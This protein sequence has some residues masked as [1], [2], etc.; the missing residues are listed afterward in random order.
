[1]TLQSIVWKKRI[2]NKFISLIPTNLNDGIA[3]GTIMNGWATGA[4]DFVD[5]MAKTKDD[6]AL[7]GLQVVVTN[8]FKGENV[9]A[10][11]VEDLFGS[12][13]TY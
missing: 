13:K 6:T 7:A 3:S 10:K 5:A 12:V 2:W 11:V 1:M 9:E 4:K 8:F